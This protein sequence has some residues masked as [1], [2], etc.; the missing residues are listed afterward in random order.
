[1]IKIVLIIILLVLIIIFKNKIEN[2]T[3][4]EG[5]KNMLSLYLNNNGVTTVNNLVIKNNIDISGNVNGN[6]KGNV[7]SPNGIFSLSIDNSGNINIFNN[8]NKEQKTI[9]M[10][11]LSNED[12]TYRLSIDVNGVLRLKKKDETTNEYSNVNIP[13]NYTGR[14]WSPL[15][16]FNMIVHNRAES[17]LIQTFAY[18]KTKNTNTM[19]KNIR[20]DTNFENV[21]VDTNNLQFD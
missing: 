16:D 3:S 5:I 13:G 1:M 7:T 18:D 9:S 20:I 19:Y 8:S 15:G 10:H 21:E 17:G 2:F 14:F 6:L 4:E 12:D 11:Y